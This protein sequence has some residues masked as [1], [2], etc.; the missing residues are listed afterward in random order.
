M[1]ECTSTSPLKTVR[2]CRAGAAVVGDTDAPVLDEPPL[3]GIG[4]GVPV[5]VAT[6]IAS[7]VEG[8]S[9]TDPDVTTAALTSSVEVDPCEQAAT[10]N[11]DNASTV[12]TSRFLRTARS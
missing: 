2:R 4:A 1:L 10:S 8:V 9:A 6:S 7:A 3:D 5:L 12:V 11:I